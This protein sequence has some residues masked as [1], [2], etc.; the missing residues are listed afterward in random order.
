MAIDAHAWNAAPAN[1]IRPPRRRPPACGT[2]GTAMA[3]STQTLAPGALAERERVLRI[4]RAHEAEIRAQGGDPA[5]PVRLDGARRGG[6]RERRRSDADI[7]QAARFSLID[8]VGLQYYL[9]D[10]VGRAVDV[11][12]TVAKMRP[13]MRQRFEA[14]AIDVF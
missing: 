9:A 14:E 3:A 6:A 7:D 1:R 13:R 4:L 11:G 5:A 8:L 12:T 2:M 10:L